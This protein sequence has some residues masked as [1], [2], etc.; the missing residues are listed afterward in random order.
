MSGMSAKRKLPTSPKRLM[1]APPPVSG[2]VSADLYL[3]KTEAASART[4]NLG[5]AVVFIEIE[6]LKNTFALPRNK[7]VPFCRMERN[8]AVATRVAATRTPLSIENC[9]S[10][11]NFLHRRSRREGIDLPDPLLSQLQ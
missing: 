1:P 4:N 6:L 10:Q 2:P 8:R 3:L 7:L 9:Y 11:P 5:I